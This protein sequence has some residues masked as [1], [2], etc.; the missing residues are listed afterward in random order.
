MEKH[1]DIPHAD[2]VVGEKGSENQAY[3]EGYVTGIF[4][5]QG[6]KKIEGLELEKSERDITI[7]KFAEEAVTQY[8]KQYGRK[9][10][11]VLPL[12][13]VHLLK[14][15]GTKEYT[16]GKLSEGGFSGKIGS[17][18][19]DRVKSDIE[20][21]LFAFHELFHSKSFHILQRTKADA[22]GRQEITE[23]RGGF[24]VTT[25]DGKTDY[26]YDVQEAIIGLMTKRFYED[27]VTTSPLFK[28][29]LDASRTAINL[30]SEREMRKLDAFI[31]ELWNENAEYF[32]TR[33]EILGLFIDAQVNGKM[34][35]VARLI[36][37]TFGKGSFRELAEETSMKRGG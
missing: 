36:E 10:D 33:E 18:L 29:E 22:Q 16:E 24:V 13:K 4:Q 30:G 15:G 32:K 25:R 9:K 11:I 6:V 37:K 23:Y 21:S 20:F 5:N 1:F 17:V 2:K 12:N 19:V 31:D 34:L 14:E 3:L 26:F 35:K 7:I 27:Y 8:M 28:D